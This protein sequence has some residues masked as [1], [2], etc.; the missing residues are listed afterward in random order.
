MR[1][2]RERGEQ[3]KRERNENGERETRERVVSAAA[4]VNPSLMLII[5]NMMERSTVPV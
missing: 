5:V 1:V 3:R 2:S 4:P